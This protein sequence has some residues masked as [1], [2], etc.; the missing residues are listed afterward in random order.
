MISYRIINK[1]T[2]YHIE[3]KKKIHPQNDTTKVNPM[4]KSEWRRYV[5]NR[6]RHLKFCVLP[7]RLLM[8]IEY[9]IDFRIFLHVILNYLHK[10]GFSFR[11]TRKELMVVEDC[12][13][14]VFFCRFG[15]AF[16]VTHVS[17]FLREFYFTHTDVYIFHTPSF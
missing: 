1:H 10:T 2:E 16:S 15:K 13:F 7:Q 9:K 14:I 6:V 12:K 3:R 17:S 11:I 5:T 8:T 4:V